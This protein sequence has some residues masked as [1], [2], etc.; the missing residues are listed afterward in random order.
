MSRSGFNI[1]LE[2]SA[3][4]AKIRSARFRVDSPAE[5]V[6]RGREVEFEH[7]GIKALRLE[8]AHELTVM[9]VPLIEGLLHQR[10]GTH[11]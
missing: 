3:L 10:S 4:A 2:A 8:V 6:E 11:V 9:A 7:S 1:E 5:A